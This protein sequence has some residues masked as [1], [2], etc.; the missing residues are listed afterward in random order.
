MWRRVDEPTPATLAEA[1]GVADHVALDPIE[2]LANRGSPLRQR[3]TAERRHDRVRW[4]GVR[5]H[6]RHA[7]PVACRDVCGM[8]QQFAGIL[9]VQVRRATAPFGRHRLLPPGPATGRNTR[10]W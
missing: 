1:E 10:S 7:L 6:I 9:R 3:L 8:P 4:A 2:N 5:R